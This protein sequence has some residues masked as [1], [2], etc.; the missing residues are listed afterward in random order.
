MNHPIA[1]KSSGILPSSTC[2]TVSYNN[3]QIC[4]DFP[5]IGQ[6]CVNAGFLPSGSGTAQACVSYK[7]PDCAQICVSVNGTQLGCVT[8]CA[9]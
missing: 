2:L 9:T 7:W 6:Y 3:G 5:F 8:Q 4:A 1:T